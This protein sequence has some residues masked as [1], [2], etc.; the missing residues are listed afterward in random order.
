MS[1]STRVRSTGAYTKIVAGM[2]LGATMTVS[3]SSA[4]DAKTAQ[5]ED[6]LE[7]I[8]VTGS[9]ITDP[10]RESSSPIAI[11]TAEDIQQS[12]AV[13]IEAA[14]NQMPQFAPSGSAG[15]GGQGTGGHATVNLRG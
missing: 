1:H 2:A 14:L 12:G 3:V 11:T 10:N 15:N 4:Q 13:A 9:L 7:E 6:S 8:I 5:A